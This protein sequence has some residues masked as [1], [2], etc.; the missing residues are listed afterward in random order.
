MHKAVA[1]FMDEPDAINAVGTVTTLGGSRLSPTG[2][3]YMTRYSD[4]FV[5]IGELERR[6]AQVAAEVFGVE[7]ACVTAGAAA[8]LA[9]S[10]AG[11]MTQGNV[12]RVRQLPDTEGMPGDV[13]V[14]KSHRILY[15]VGVRLA[16]GRF[17]EVGVTAEA[18]P[19]QLAA[20]LSDSTAM[21][22]Y[23]D[24]CK[25]MRGSIPL[26]EVTAIA[27]RA[28]VPVVVDAA[29][30][31]PPFTRPAE[32]LAAGADAVVVSGG[33]E[34][35]GP[36]SSGLILGKHTIIDWSRA[37]NFPRY[38]IGRCMKFDRETLF[39]LL[40]ALEDLGNRDEGNV[41]AANSDIADSLLSAISQLQG[42]EVARGYVTGPGVQPTNIP[43]VFVRHQELDAETLAEKLLHWQ[44]PVHV[45]TGDGMVILNVQ[46]LR[47]E[48]VSQV[49][50][51]LRSAGR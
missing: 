17:R 27:A 24:E 11:C 34:L 3:D 30:E 16:G 46:T 19:E 1:S 22:L 41:V 23:A 6:V 39:G 45:R 14:L 10:T 50:S 32:L 38:G 15:D 28:G 42:Y 51:A 25:D 21:V 33:K 40:G 7:A 36:Q 4:R 35:G 31:I 5:D 44:V 47:P 9:I 12:A 8:G 26:H 48:D 13:V 49:T 2:R 18:L 20:A 37:N 43:R 29:A